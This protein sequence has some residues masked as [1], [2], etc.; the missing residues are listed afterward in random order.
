MYY[1]IYA[2]DKP[3][4]LQLR[5]ETRPAHFEYARAQDCIMLAGPLLSEG[6][7]PEMRGSMF[8]ID[9]ADRAG[10]EAFAAADPYAIAGLFAAV[11]IK[12][13]K[14]AIGPWKPEDV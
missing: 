8:I 3:D 10:A 9:V 12:S 14:P 5:M 13:W 6:D 7:E 1:I 11:E 2:K 4:S